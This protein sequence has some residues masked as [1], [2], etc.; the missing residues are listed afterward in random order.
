[1]SVFIF[2]S[3]H[4]THGVSQD[5]TW[6]EAASVSSFP[7]LSCEQPSL[8]SESFLKNSDPAGHLT[9][10][11]ILVTGSAL[12]DAWPRIGSVSEKWEEKGQQWMKWLDGDTN[13]M[14]VT[15][16]KVWGRV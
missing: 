1:M 9:R 2:Q 15:L 8:R 10:L 16:S 11:G 5:Q 12:K 7:S 3:P 4:S 6:P 13:S 14:D